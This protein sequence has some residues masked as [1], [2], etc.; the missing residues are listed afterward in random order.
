MCV[1]R[2]RIVLCT[3]YC[4]ARGVF[5][6]VFVCVCVSFC[7][8]V[9]SCF[10]CVFV[11]PCVV[12]FSSAESTLVAV[13]L[14]LLCCH[15][16]LKDSP[17]VETKEI[18][19]LRFSDRPKKDLQ[20]HWE[21]ECV[22]TTSPPQPRSV[23][24]SHR[25]DSLRAGRGCSDSV[26]TSPPLHTAGQ[27]HHKTHAF[28]HGKPQRDSSEQT[29]GFNAHTLPRHPNHHCTHIQL[30]IQLHIQDAAHTT[31]KN[32]PHPG[33]R[34]QA[35]AQGSRQ[36]TPIQ[37]HRKVDNTHPP[38][39]PPGDAPGV[40][41]ARSPTACQCPTPLPPSA[42]GLTRDCHR[43]N[44]RRTVHCRGPWAWTS[45][46]PPRRRCCCWTATRLALHGLAS[47]PLA[48]P[49]S[50][51]RRCAVVAGPCCYCEPRT[52]RSSR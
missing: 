33:T 13:L 41:A 17:V 21:K 38:T 1:C 36:N 19:A 30:H 45:A 39:H 46:P 40:P 20:F 29:Q 7:V 23:G 44:R 8:S 15:K 26:T 12:V 52:S 32:D 37:M 14:F 22:K 16:I 10:T 25:V 3:V 48:V 42:P 9:T 27:G 11:C 2:V 43:V 51:R 47:A 28:R 31:R 4:V 5:V 6:C 34:T 49:P 50:V 35:A 18:E 24:Q